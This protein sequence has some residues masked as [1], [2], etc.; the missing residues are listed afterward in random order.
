M[1]LLNAWKEPQKGVWKTNRKKRL[2]ES[3][4][5]SLNFAKNRFHHSRFPANFLKV[6]KKRRTVA[7]WQKLTRIKSDLV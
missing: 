2:A 4:S 6:F 3:I 7:L 1:F 5:N